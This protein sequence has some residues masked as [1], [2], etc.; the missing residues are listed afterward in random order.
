MKF[1]LEIEPICD[2]TPDD[3]IEYLTEKMRHCKNNFKIE[4][5]DEDWLPDVPENIGLLISQNEVK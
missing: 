3:I 4:S 2:E 1:L 5:L